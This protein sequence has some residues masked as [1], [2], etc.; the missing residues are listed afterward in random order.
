MELST[1]LISLDCC[2]IVFASEMTITKAILRGFGSPEGIPKQNNEAEASLP[3]TPIAL[4]L[5]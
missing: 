2:S 1:F 4:G 3:F 5:G